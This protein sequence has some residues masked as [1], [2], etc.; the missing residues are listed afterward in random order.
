V[1]GKG[2]FQQQRREVH[3]QA[4]QRHLRR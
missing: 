2:I 3:R 1:S 4:S